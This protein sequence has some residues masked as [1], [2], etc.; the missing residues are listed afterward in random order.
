VSEAGRCPFTA[1]P[2]G[3][4]EGSL[5]ARHCAGEAERTKHFAMRQRERMR[6]KVEAR[7]ARVAASS[8]R[9]AG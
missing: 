2:C 8:G 3:C 6:R 1:L 7:K 5:M 4:L 9:A